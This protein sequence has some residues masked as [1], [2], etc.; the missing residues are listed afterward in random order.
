MRGSRPSHPPLRELPQAAGPPGPGLSRRAPACPSPRPHGTGPGSGSG[1]G[2]GGSGGRARCTES[3][4]VH[5]SRSPQPRAPSPTARFSR[6]PAPRTAPAAR[7][8]GCGRPPRA[9]GP[10]ARPPRCAA[11]PCR[12]LAQPRPGNKAGGAR[13]SPGAACR[14]GRRAAAARAPPYAAGPGTD[15]PRARLPACGALSELPGATVLGAEDRPGSAAAAAAAAGSKCGSETGRESRSAQRP[16]PPRA[17]R[18]GPRGVFICHIQ[19]GEGGG[20]T[21]IFHLP[22]RMARGRKLGTARA[23]PQ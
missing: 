19:A 7:G 21:K 1:S 9:A 2:S 13:C 18:P 14:R 5:D 20:G 10:A 6:V 15:S 12:R 17:R 4:R 3:R 23:R 8:Q 22:R 11:L 16:P